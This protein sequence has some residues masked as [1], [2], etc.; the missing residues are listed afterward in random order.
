MACYEYC[1][2]TAC[3]HSNANSCALSF[4]IHVLSIIFP[5]WRAFSL[6]NEVLS[7]KFPNSTAFSLQNHVLWVLRIHMLPICTFMCCQEQ[8]YMLWV[9]GFRMICFEFPES[10]AFSSLM[11]NDMLSVS[12]ITCFQFT[13]AE[14]HAFNF[15]NYLLSVSRMTWKFAESR[16]F[17][18]QDHMLSISKFVCFQFLLEIPNS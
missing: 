17:S 5:N 4:Q 7:I 14:W 6:H 16:A 13:D 15:H 12:R 9:C 1:S 2:K 18:L 3:F 8:N 10:P 11:Q